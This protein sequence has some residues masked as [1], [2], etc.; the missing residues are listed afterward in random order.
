[1]KKTTCILG[2]LLIMLSFSVNAQQKAEKL[3]SQR[4]VTG[5]IGILT[6]SNVNINEVHLYITIT[7]YPL[8]SQPTGLV[9]YQKHYVGESYVE[10]HCP[11]MFTS[12]ADV[13]VRVVYQDYE[14]VQHPAIDGW[15]F[16]AL[17]GIAYPQ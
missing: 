14:Q 8:S 6:T 5:K 17:M 3:N 11:Y 15:E 9:T 10:D 16:N 4:G 7:G 13:T 1:M 12:A 2:I